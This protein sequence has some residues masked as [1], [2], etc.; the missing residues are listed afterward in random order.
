MDI[1]ELVYLAQQG[2]P[3]AQ[4]KLAEYYLLGEGVEENETEAVRWY[5]EAT[6]LGVA[7]VEFMI[8]L[9]FE[10]GHYS[11]KDVQKGMCWIRRAAEHGLDKAQ[12]V[13]G[14]RYAEKKPLQSFEMITGRDLYH[15]EGE[16]NQQEAVCWIR[17]AAEQGFAMS[18]VLLGCFYFSGSGV[19][20]NYQES[21]HWCKK[22]MGQ[23]DV[24]AKECAEK[25][26][27]LLENSRVEYICF[28]IFLGVFGAHNLLVAKYFGK[29]IAQLCITLFSCGCLSPIVFVWAMIDVFTVRKNRF[30]IPFR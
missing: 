8:G 3:D 16:K 27:D 6:K 9:F 12:H 14:L 23:G 24:R 22:A 17:K 10:D 29:G 19:E 2:V 20:K 1:T 5:C 30:G 18:Q 11:R 13:M 26:L 21:L 15:T 28:A 7:E 25:Y 4:L